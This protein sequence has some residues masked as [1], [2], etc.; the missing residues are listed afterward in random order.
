MAGIRSSIKLLF[1]V[2]PK[3]STGKSHEGIPLKENTTPINRHLKLFSSAAE[4]RCK[5]V[6]MY[7]SQV[8]LVVIKLMIRAFG[9]RV[10][11]SYC[12][13]ELKMHEQGTV[14]AAATLSY[15]S[16]RNRWRHR[17]LPA[18]TNYLELQSRTSVQQCPPPKRTGPCCL[19]LK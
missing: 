3:N 11:V 8:L 12:F 5:L 19:S 7:Y 15:G 9:R 1:T 6:A 4:V 2:R 17:T 10:A 14:D 13:V 18:A 16:G